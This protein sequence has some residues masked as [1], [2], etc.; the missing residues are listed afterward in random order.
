MNFPTAMCIFNFRSTPHYSRIC[1]LSLFLFLIVFVFIGCGSHSHRY[2]NA[3]VKDNKDGVW[4]QKNS[5]INQ[6]YRQY[7]SRGSRHVKISLQRA[8]KYLPYIHRVFRKYKLP[9][10]LAY[11]PILESGFVTDAK[12][13]TGATGMWQFIT[14]T[15]RE[16]NLKVTWYKDERKNWKKST[17]AAAQYLDYLGKKFNYNWELALA[18]YN[19]GQGYIRRQMKKQGTWNYWNLKIRKEPYD[20]VPK[21]LSMLRVAREKY[22]DLYRKGA[23]KFWVASI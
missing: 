4:T 6:F 11:L 16:Y 5:R 20:Y 8:Q 23:P 7:S 9:P 17:I 1:V 19:A 18:S 2:R 15:G 3:K 10:E 13:R 21:F 12:S 22:P 14:S